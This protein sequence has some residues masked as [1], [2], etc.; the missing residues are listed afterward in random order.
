MGWIAEVRRYGEERQ[1]L[2]QL[3]HSLDD[4]GRR[5]SDETAGLKTKS[6]AFQKAIST[7]G[8]EADLILSEIAEM[9]TRQAIIR[10]QRWRVPIP[11]RPYGNRGQD[12]DFWEWSV[13]HG[14]YYLTDHGLREVRKMVHDERE[15][16]SR[17][18]I[19][20]AALAISVI[21]LI[22]SALKP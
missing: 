15:M 13:A 6:D 7:Y 20:W 18:I 11:Q 3:R 2:I 10:A 17:P 1:N 4:L 12:T 5:M 9:E 21:S 16:L 8:H 14:L 22:V 19:T